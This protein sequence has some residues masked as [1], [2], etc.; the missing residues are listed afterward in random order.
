MERVDYTRCL[1]RGKNSQSPGVAK[2][3]GYHSSYRN[4]AESAEKNKENI[5][6]F[7]ACS[8]NVTDCPLK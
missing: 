4:I 6:A 3:G 8:G 5:S 2:K 1:F 7:S